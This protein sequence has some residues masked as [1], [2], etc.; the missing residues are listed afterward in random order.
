MSAASY[1]PK[2][3]KLMTFHD[4]AGTFR[5][6]SDTPRDATSASE[7]PAKPCRA[8]SSSATSRI[9]SREDTGEAAETF[10]AMARILP[11]DR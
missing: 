8:K 7:T 3:H 4:A 11:T 6:G 2:S 1:D 10:L 5:D 9:F